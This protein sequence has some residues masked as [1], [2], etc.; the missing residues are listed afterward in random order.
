MSTKS[1]QCSDCNEII[2]Y[3]DNFGIP[4]QVIIGCFVCRKCKPNHKL[5][6]EQSIAPDAIHALNKKSRA[7]DW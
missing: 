2:G 1:I 7:T 3:F 4:S 5:L 6:T